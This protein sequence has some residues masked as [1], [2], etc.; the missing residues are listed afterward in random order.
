MPWSQ[1]AANVARTRRQPPGGWGGA[2]WIAPA[3]P[4][5]LPPPLA[6]PPRAPRPPPPPPPNSPARPLVATDDVALIWVAV[7]VPLELFVPWTMTVSP[8]WMAPA[9]AVAVRLIFEWLVVFT[10][11]VLPSLSL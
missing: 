9:L 8:G 4:P 11:I 10:R 6:P 5:A 7:I 2:L 3:P 1:P